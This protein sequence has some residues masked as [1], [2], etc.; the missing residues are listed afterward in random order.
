MFR[1]FFKVEKGNFIDTFAP[2]NG[3]LQKYKWPRDHRTRDAG[4][5]ANG[6]LVHHI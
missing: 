5:Y 4:E 3:N 1:L 2:G 6:S